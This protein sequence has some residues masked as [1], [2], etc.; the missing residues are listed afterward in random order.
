MV[1]YVRIFT[2]IK[3]HK[4]AALR[5]RGILQ[6][7][8]GATMDKTQSPLPSNCCRGRYASSSSLL[9]AR[10]WPLTSEAALSAWLGV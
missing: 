7:V 2:R 4:A 3:C 6:C 8:S 9:W 1:V 5:L 10:C